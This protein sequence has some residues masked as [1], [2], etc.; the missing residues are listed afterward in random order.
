[1]DLRRLRTGKWMLAAGSALLLVSLVTSWYEARQVV[2][3]LPAPSGD[4]T[5]TAFEAFSGVEFNRQIPVVEDLYK[6]LGFVLAAG[7]L[8]GLALVVASAMQRVPA[9]SIAGWSVMALIALGLL[10]LVLIPTVKIPDFHATRGLV[11]DSSRDPG[12]W[13]AL[14]GCLLMVVGSLASIRDASLKGGGRR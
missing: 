11:L 14:A 2:V 5:L 9:V 7:A 12:I 13:L 1:M 3:Q 10:V 8:L 4:Y 6:T